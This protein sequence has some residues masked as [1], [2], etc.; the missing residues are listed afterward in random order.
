MTEL[1]PVTV[2]LHHEDLLLAEREAEALGVGV[3]VYL[4]ILVRQGLRHEEAKSKESKRADALLQFSRAMSAEA[5]RK[6]YSEKDLN[7][8]TKK[9]R[10]T[11]AS[12]RREH[13][14]NSQK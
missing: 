13:R 12:K 6:N 9:A 1:K 4:R 8:T 10:H 3:G 14:A 5:Q 2:R 11:V 7:A